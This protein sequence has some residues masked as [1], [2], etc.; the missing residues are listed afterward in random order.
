MTFL[1]AHFLKDQVLYLV[2]EHPDTPVQILCGIHCQMPD[3]PAGHGQVCSEQSIGQAAAVLFESG[4]QSGR[5][6]IAQHCLEGLVNPLV[7][8]SP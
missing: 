5:N 3:S 2:G 7:H 6:E 1:V 4:R 8:A